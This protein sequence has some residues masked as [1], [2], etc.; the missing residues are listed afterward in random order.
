MRVI[1]GFGV[2]MLAVIG[3]IGAAF[4]APLAALVIALSRRKDDEPSGGAFLLRWVQCTV[5]VIVVL[6]LGLSGNAAS[7]V[8]V[9]GAEIEDLL[10]MAPWLL[11]LAAGIHF[12]FRWAQRP[13]GPPR[14]PPNDD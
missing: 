8:A 2:V 11:L 14:R 12:G 10:A 13:P 4:G 7:G 3:A 6:C 1:L 5:V 9:H